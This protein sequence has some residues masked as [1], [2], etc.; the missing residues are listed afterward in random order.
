MWLLFSVGGVLTALFVPILL[1]LFGIA[2]PLGWMTPPDHTHLVAVLQYHLIRVALLA[3]C[4][5]AFFH[6]AYRFRY[7]LRDSMQL[8]HATRIVTTACYASAITGSI[9]AGYILLG[10]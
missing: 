8:K 2:F 1:L 9:V 5:F 7:I 4:V 3:L 6:C 10:A